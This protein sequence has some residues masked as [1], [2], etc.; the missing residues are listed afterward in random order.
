MHEEKN[1]PTLKQMRYYNE[2]DKK[3]RNMDQFNL[4]AMDCIMTHHK[5]NSFFLISSNYE[6]NDMTIITTLHSYLYSEK[7]F[8]YKLLILNFRRYRS[9]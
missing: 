1:G 6:D 4:V 9:H 3:E 2:R 7:L 5:K 8:N